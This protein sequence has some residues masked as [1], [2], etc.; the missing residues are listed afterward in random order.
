[1]RI[2][3]VT[4]HLY[5]TAQEIRVTKF[6]ASLSAQG[7]EF[8]VF[9]PGHAGLKECDKFSHGRIRRL[10]PARWLGRMGKLLFAPLPINP[11]WLKW[12]CERFKAESL[13]LVIV[14]DLRLA[15]PVYFAARLCGIKAVLDLGEHY[16]GMMEIIGKQNLVHYIIRNDSLIRWLEKISVSLADAVWV[17]V[18]ENRQRLERYAKHI[19]VINNYP[20]TEG[21]SFGKQCMH[22]GWSR[23]G[24]PVTLISLG[25]IDNIRGLDLAIEA[26]EIVERELGNVRF[27][28]YGDGVFRP[29]LERMVQARHLEAKVIFGGW[30]SEEK[31]YDLMADGDIGLVLHK[32]CDLT[33]H[34]IPNKLFDYMAVGLPVAATRLR[35]VARILE[36]ED[37]GV[38]MEENAG[39]VAAGLIELIV[40]TKRREQMGRNGREAVKTRYSWHTESK[41]ILTEIDRLICVD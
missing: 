10:I 23:T 41:K 5:P 9:C 36:F 28:I 2:G 32:V 7:H 11:F 3:C 24:E 25:L 1:M 35:P 13:D 22:R 40:D 19:Q 37:C 29:E 31:K 17:V 14:R 38:C 26:F 33:Q 30:V 34:T 12:L 39:A 21:N 6:A 18:D 4:R 20:A 16:P 8:L 15:L 27:V